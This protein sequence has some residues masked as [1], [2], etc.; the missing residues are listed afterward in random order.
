MELEI[1]KFFRNGG[2]IQEL[3][4][5]FFIYA[6]RHSE[7]NNLVLFK[8]DQI[9]SNFEL[10]IV[11][12]C[13]GIILDEANNWNIVSFPFKKFFNYGEKNAANID[14]NTAKTFLKADGSLAVL[15]SYDNKW[16]MAT[17]GSPDAGGQVNDFGFTFK[18]LFW[19]TFN[20]PLPPIDCGKCFFF[21]LTSPYNKIVVLHKEASLTLLGGRNLS[22][23]Y[24]ELTLKEASVF[25]PDCP[26]V[27]EFPLYSF[28]D[29][30]NS[31]KTFKGTEQE[32]FVICD[33]N[34]DRNKTKHPDYVIAHRLKDRMSSRRAIV[35]VVLL[36]EIEEVII[37]LPEFAEPLNEANA[38]L[39]SLIDEL[40]TEY[41]T[42]K[43]IEVQKDFAIAVKGSRCSSALFALRA[44]KVKSIR[45]HLCKMI[46]DNVMHL[47]GYKPSKE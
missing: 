27:K 26:V 43:H 47:L 6:K 7:Y 41:N 22:D 8:Y 29:I 21:E 36:G 23:D 15:Y 24:K 11:C 31:Y 35:E 40:E 12:E 2:S 14:W 44:G 37:C 9:F 20:Y 39:N 34:F 5:K 13:R 30:I 32:G 25:F 19:K 17:S 3:E 10:P 1:Q 4:D 33:G 46:I 42:N 16:H 18:E 45:E 38:R 28:E